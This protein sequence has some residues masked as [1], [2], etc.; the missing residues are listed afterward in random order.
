MDASDEEFMKVD[1]LEELHHLLCLSQSQRERE[2]D[3]IMVFYYYYYSNMSNIRCRQMMAR[4]LTYQTHIC[5]TM[6]TW[7]RFSHYTTV[8]F[9]AFSHKSP[10]PEASPSLNQR[11]GKEE[12]EKEGK[13]THNIAI[14]EIW[15][16][17]LHSNNN[18]PTDY[19]SAHIFP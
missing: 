6:T 10:Y 2:I 14:Y 15:L 19:V 1:S 3:S 16:H 17:L 11:K 12:E 13:P 4:L 5:L 9:G 8:H 18:T 7:L